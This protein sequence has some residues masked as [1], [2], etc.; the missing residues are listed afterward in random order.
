M[1]RDNYP[2]DIVVTWVD[3]SDEKWLERRKAYD[4]AEPAE[5]S[6][7]DEWT[8]GEVRYR[9]WGTL[10]YWFRMVSENCPWVRYVHFVT[11]GHLPEWLDVNCPKLRIVK[12]EDY[13]PAKYLPTFNSHTIELN[14]HR[15]P[16][17]AE[18][19]VYFNDDVFPIA[20]TKSTD[21]FKNGLP[22]DA[23]A[24]NAIS[25]D[26]NNKLML[27]YNNVAVI[28]KHFSKNKVIAANLT[29]WFSPVYGS[30]ML[31][32]LC[33][34]PWPRFTGFYEHHT[35]YPFLKSTIEMLWEK[36]YEELDNT[37]SCKFRRWDNVT[38][39][40]IRNWQNVTGRFVPQSQSFHKSYA[41]S[42]DDEI[43]GEI[44]HPK[45]P[46]ICVNDSAA[47]DAFERERTMLIEAMDEVFPRPS[48]FEVK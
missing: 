31:R 43:L 21:F 36:E 10:K 17:L 37:C 4:S 1:K 47:A 19:F 2:I 25:R 24:L 33:L 18:H 41:H 39:Y 26:S 20:K 6:I 13:I 15:I 35:A 23:V 14:F 32:T 3:G 5:K 44:R 11:W 28:N 22:R 40:L 48:I 7:S 38:P 8:K 46:V 12:H 27:Q 9:D 45:H 34:M 42:I 16:D 29:K 30:L